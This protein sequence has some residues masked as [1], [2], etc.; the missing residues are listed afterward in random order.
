MPARD[1][2]QQLR[3]AP[4]GLTSG[5][6]RINARGLLPGSSVAGTSIALPGLRRLVTRGD[7]LGV[8]T[9]V[10]AV[11]LNHGTATPIYDLR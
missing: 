9:I 6:M 3:K 2:A 8:M 11:G 10:R 7:I 5:E 1:E 4:L